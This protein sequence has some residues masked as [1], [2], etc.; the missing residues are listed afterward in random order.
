M[1][2]YAF[3]L[4]SNYLCEYKMYIVSTSYTVNERLPSPA[5]HSGITK[6]KRT[7][8][9]KEITVVSVCLLALSG[10]PQSSEQLLQRGCPLVPETT[11]LITMQQKHSDRRLL[12]FLTHR[13]A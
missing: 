7:L 8:S 1:S 12:S 3:N 13:Q 10:S 6:S 5:R 11:T 4:L 2:E 9:V